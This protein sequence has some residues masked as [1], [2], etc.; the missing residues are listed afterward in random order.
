MVDEGVYWSPI[1][2][3]VRLTACNCCYGDDCVTCFSLLLGGLLH[4]VEEVGRLSYISKGHL[5]K[6]NQ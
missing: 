6:H 2:C 5:V 3:S 4:Y 1:M